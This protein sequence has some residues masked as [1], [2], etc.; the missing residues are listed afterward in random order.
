MTRIKKIAGFGI[1]GV[2]A[3]SAA[4]FALPRHVSVERSAVIDAEADA[5]IALA[6]SNEG[7]QTFNPYKSMDPE[8]RIELFGPQA[9]VGSGFHFDGTDGTGSQTVSAV[10]EDQVVYAID[11]GALGQPVQSIKAVPVAD[12]AEVT[13]RVDS[14]LGFNPIFRVFGL[15]MEDMMGPTF[16]LG[17]ENLSRAAA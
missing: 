3:V 10:S 5:I 9:G 7:F 16:E 8:L 15:F 6:A 14:D 11:L 4:A 1:A 12:G 2:L 17:L 13:W